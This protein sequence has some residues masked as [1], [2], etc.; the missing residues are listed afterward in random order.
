MTNRACTRVLIQGR[1]TYNY[2]YSFS[3]DFSYE[4]DETSFAYCIPYTYSQLNDH[5]LQWKSLHT[6]IFKHQT[7]WK[8]LSGLPVPVITITDDS[9]DSS[10]KSLVVVCARVHPG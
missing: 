2:I 6:P 4:D 5:I 10:I 8:T 1:L 7:L 3:Y 9:I